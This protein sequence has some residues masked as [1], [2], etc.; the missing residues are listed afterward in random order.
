[1]KRTYFYTFWAKVSLPKLGY[2]PVV[3]DSVYI[4]VRKDMF[5]DKQPHYDR[6]SVMK[7]LVADKQDMRQELGEFED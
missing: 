5:R 1:M 4:L 7:Q 3:V 2:I 6:R